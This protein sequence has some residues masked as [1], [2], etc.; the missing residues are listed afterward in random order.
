[1]ANCVFWLS[2]DRMIDDAAGRRIRITA[3]ASFP[4]AHWKKIWSTNPLG[5]LVREMKRRAGPGLS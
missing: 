4:S 3:F 1:V 5:R 2:I